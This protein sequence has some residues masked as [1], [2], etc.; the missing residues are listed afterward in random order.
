MREGKAPEPNCCEKLI[1]KTILYLHALVCYGVYKI[2]IFIL[3]LMQFSMIVE[4]WTGVG[5]V[6]ILRGV[7]KDW[8]RGSYHFILRKIS[9]KMRQFIK[10]KNSTHRGGSRGQNKS[11]KE[12]TIGAQRA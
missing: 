4:L 6:L 10:N 11:V 1:K 12:I 8:E 5:R 7:M 9:I 3:S 2:G